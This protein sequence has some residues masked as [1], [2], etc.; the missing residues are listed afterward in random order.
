MTGKI[1]NLDA[2]ARLRTSLNNKIP[3]LD[4]EAR[5]RTSLNNK[6]NRKVNKEH[7]VNKIRIVVNIVLSYRRLLM[8]IIID[9]FY[10]III[11]S[12]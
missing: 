6:N 8:S 3:N 10:K 11:F 2:E 1:P 9:I 4:A 5:L 12:M 7:L